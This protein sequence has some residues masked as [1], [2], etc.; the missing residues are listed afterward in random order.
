MNL[1]VITSEEQEQAVK[2]AQAT[3]TQVLTLAE[4]VV[5]TNDAEYQS[6]NDGFVAGKRALKSIKAKRDEIVGPL[7]DVVKKLEAGFKQAE[8]AV[9]MALLRYER[10]MAA[11]QEKLRLEREEKERAARAEADRL[12]AEAEARAKAELREAEQLREEGR[13]KA[14]LAKDNPFGAVLAEEAARDLEEQADARIETA[15]R[16][17]R[18]SATVQVVADVAPKVTAAGSRVLTQWK[19]RVKDAN[20][21]PREYWVLDDAKLARVARE[22]KGALEI[23][24]VEIYA[25]TKIGGA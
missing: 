7:K 5:V 24:G 16:A 2:A 1:A 9:N 11:Y 6:A 25:E 18:E 4:H 23:P 3:S 10:P 22:T 17:F 19:H 20:L 14:E 15:K 8:E 21:V 13:R 12:K